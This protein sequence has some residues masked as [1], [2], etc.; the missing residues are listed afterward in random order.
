MPVA[1]AIPNPTRKQMWY[2]QN[3]LFNEKTIRYGRVYSQIRY[4][5]NGHIENIVAPKAPVSRFNTRTWYENDG[6]LHIEKRIDSKT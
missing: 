6:L 5:K 2:D 4:D 3:G 1:E